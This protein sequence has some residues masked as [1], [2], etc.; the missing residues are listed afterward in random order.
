MTMPQG[1]TQRWSLDFV[2]DALADGRR[3]RCLCVTDD[4][5]RE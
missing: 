3:F 5:S 4:F 1:P 2:S